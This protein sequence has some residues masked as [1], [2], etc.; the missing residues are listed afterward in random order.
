MPKKYENKAIHN[1]DF[2]Q[3][4]INDYP[5]TYFDWKVTV[6]F[7]C[8]LHRCY[9]VLLTN[10][11]VVETRHQLN[12]NNI[13][14]INPELSRSLFSVYKNSRSSRYDGFINDD[15]MERINK[16]NYQKSDS[17]LRKI[18]GIVSTYY[19]IAV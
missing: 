6:Q 17:E 1:E 7:Y 9:C 16:I 19:P 3:S 15:A 4:I 5:N 12:I 14:T 13:K 2:L 10:G 11:S 8:A 18:K